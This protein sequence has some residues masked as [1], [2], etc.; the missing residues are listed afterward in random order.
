M[1]GVDTNI[2]V[3]IFA[4]D[5]PGQARRAGS[6]IDRDAA[7]EKAFVSVVVLVEFAWT[8]RR[9]YGWERDWVLVALRKITEHPNIVVED[10]DAVRDAIVRSANHRAE[11]PDQLIAVRN[12][13]AGCRV[14]MTFD[15]DA[16]RDPGFA[17][18]TA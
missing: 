8:M 16:A 13:L 1:I 10:R 12:S 4:N 9:V 18:L 6:F 15:R 3:R 14:T 17:P 7:D 11:F 2:L 5:D